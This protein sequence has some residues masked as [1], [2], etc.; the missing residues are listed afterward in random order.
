MTSPVITFGQ[1]VRVNPDWLYQ[2]KVGRSVVS[3]TFQAKERQWLSSEGSGLMLLSDAVVV[4]L[5]NEALHKKL[6]I[7]AYRP[8]IGRSLHFS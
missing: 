3:F 4:E 7:T 6:P 1:F 2:I 5:L 8:D